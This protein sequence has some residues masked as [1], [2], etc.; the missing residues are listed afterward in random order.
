M[1][2]DLY[3]NYFNY[4]TISNRISM[5]V[6][7]SIALTPELYER[8][9]KNEINRSRICRKALETECERIEKGTR[10]TSAKTAPGCHSDRRTL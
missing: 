9:R 10:D 4:V 1:I 8:C 6:S 7:A 3:I 5:Q 2:K